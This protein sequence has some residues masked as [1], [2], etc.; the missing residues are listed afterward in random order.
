MDH[1]VE[2]RE[3]RV[4]NLMSQES[5]A[6]A[7]GISKKTIGNIERGVTSPNYINQRKFKELR[8]RYERNQHAYS[9]GN[10]TA[11]PFD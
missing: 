2:W 6:R 1:A 9:L 3:W 8:E 10:G 7:L 4:A 11:S 5:F